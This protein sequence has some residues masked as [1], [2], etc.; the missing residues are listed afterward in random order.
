MRVFSDLL[1]RVGGIIADQYKAPRPATE[2]LEKHAVF[3]PGK[4]E[5]SHTMLALLEFRAQSAQVVSFQEI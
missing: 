1:H 3:M 4:F 2:R 5:I